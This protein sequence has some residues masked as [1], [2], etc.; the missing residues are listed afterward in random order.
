MSERERPRHL[1]GFV[2]IDDAYS[3]GK[4]KGGKCGWV[5]EN[6]RSF[7]IAV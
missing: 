3:G 1:D 4:R 6:K 7:V 2:Q 5:S